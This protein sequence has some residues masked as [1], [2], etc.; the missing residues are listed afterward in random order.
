MQLTALALMCLVLNVHN[1]AAGEPPLGMVAVAE[2]TLTRA[3][4]TGKDVCTTVFKPWQ[5]SWTMEP[6]LPPPT[7][8]ELER[9]WKAVLVAISTD[10]SVTGGATHF[11]ADY[12]DPP[13][14]ADSFKQTVQIGHHI[15]YRDEGWYTRASRKAKQETAE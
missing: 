3:K 6:K 11:H 8:A 14:W 9:A 15:F 10:Q 13:H 1:E 12:I 7:Q 5:F 2:V 4:L